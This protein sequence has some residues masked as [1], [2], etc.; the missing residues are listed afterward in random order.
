M[1]RSEHHLRK[2][3]M[4][5]KWFIVDLYKH[6][7]TIQKYIL[8]VFICEY[9]IHKFINLCFRNMFIN[10]VVTSSTVSEAWFV[11]T[12]EFLISRFHTRMVQDLQWG[13][14]TFGVFLQHRSQQWN[15]LSTAFATVE[16]YILILDFVI[17]FF[18]VR[19]LAHL[20]LKR[21]MMMR[22]SIECDSEWP[23]IRSIA[24]RT[25]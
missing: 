21:E 5:D 18:D 8:K 6:P 16:I 22:Q 7:L 4:W 10:K 11:N 23:D 17:E 24:H 2:S 14:S 1:R 19:L 20:L 3:T 12:N 9:S 13:Y 25:R 15:H